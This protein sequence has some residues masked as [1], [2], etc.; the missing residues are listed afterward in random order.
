MVTSACMGMERGSGIK[1][2]DSSFSDSANAG[3]EGGE[4]GLRGL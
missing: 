4:A 2:K 1:K 3:D